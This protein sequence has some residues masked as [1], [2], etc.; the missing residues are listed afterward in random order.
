MSAQ[1]FIVEIGVEE[2][3]PTA[4]KTLSQSFT[5]A[6]TAGLT[7]AELS[8]TSSK[9][10]LAAPRRL[11]FIV[12]GLTEQG[13][14]K[15][16][17]AWGPPAKIAFDDDGKPG[18]AAIAFAN[19]NG[20]AV[21]DLAVENDGKQDKLCARSTQTGSK[22][23]D[24]LPGIVQN[25]LDQ[26]PIA[27][28]MRWG[29]SRTE[30]V[31]PV[32]WI[33]ML[34]GSDVIPAT[35]LGIDSS[36]QSRG[37][38]FHCNENITINNASD[39]E[40]ALKNAYVIVDYQV[41]QAMVAAQVKAEGENIGGHAVIGEDLLDEVTGLVEW[42][43]ALTGSF[44]DRF[45]DVPAEALI[46]SMKEHQKYFHVEDANG[47]LMPNFITVANIESNDPAQ[48]ISGNERVIRP[49]L[50]DAAFFF[51]TDKKTNL[52]ARVERLKTVVFQ[53]QLGTTYEKT[54]RISKLATYIAAHIN[55]NTDYAQ[56]AGQLC[57]ADLVSDMVLE[58]DKMQ[59][60]A[61][62]YYALNDGEP[63]EVA[64]AIREQ[65][66]PKFSGDKLPET[67][68]GCA[69]ALADRLDTLV[70]IFGVNQIPSGSKDP[71]A[72]RRAV[73]GFIRII[74][75]KQFLGLDID[76]LLIEAK[77]GLDGKI[78]ND[79]V[80]TDVNTFIMDRYRAIYQDQNVPA[81]T[82]MAVQAAI[83]ASGEHN[84]H[85]FDLRIQAVQSFRALPE[86]AALAAANKRVQNILA[87]QGGDIAVASVDAGLFNSAAETNLFE[88]ISTL[89]SD[90]AQLTQDREY[91]SALTKLATLKDSVDT[92]FDDVMVMDDDIAVRTNRVNLLRTLNQ[93][94]IQIADISVLQS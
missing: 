75:E 4:L 8:F 68:T 66:L 41:R 5:A 49:R 54:Q 52:D 39:Y 60:I 91:T 58:F 69:V 51:A 47:K 79:N 33:V 53:K 90:V 28:R 92:F 40:A 61:G 57:K 56:R 29:A 19:K 6:I 18:K 42:P 38:R 13:T 21:E 78:S 86:A 32:H 80:V 1:D 65:Y 14:D 64:N 82:V 10:L 50:D 67:L 77:N 62:M 17:V 84:P 34:F 37:H 25:A 36:N 88:L 83:K 23:V 26:L 27:K 93:Q 35:I 16:I 2:L 71:F 55:G 89:T 7:E 45:L 70:G 85:D 44:E 20:I 59:G 94:F 81:D 72:L 9:E 22:A 11:A 15:E 12:E 43:V 74:S 46:S 30:F 76:S 63:A 48:V 87:K 3:P 31:R 73:L 24:V